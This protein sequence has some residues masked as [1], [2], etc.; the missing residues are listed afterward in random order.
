MF[1]LFK[2]FPLYSRNVKLLDINKEMYFF[3]LL[4]SIK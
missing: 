3:Q 1:K 2:Y 4:E